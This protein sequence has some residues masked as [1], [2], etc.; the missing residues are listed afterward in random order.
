[1]PLFSFSRFA[2]FFQI[3]ASH[4]AC[5]RLIFAC[6]IFSD[7]VVFH[8]QP[9]TYFAVYYW[10]LPLLSAIF[11]WSARHALLPPFSPPRLSPPAAAAAISFDAAMPC[12]VFVLP[13]PPPSQ[14]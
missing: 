14:V 6:Q 10:L 4:A 7:T 5:F 8:F 1:L 9:F 13:P 2:G 11:G 12:R 3:S